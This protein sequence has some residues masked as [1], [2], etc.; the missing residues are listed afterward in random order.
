MNAMEL[1][2][3]QL[4]K[5]TARIGREVEE[6]LRDHTVEPHYSAERTAALLEIT[7]RTV[8]N[9]VDLGERT[10]GKEGIYP[11]VKIS[12]KVVRIPASSINRWLKS[13]TITVA[14]R[15]LHEAIV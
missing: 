14:T 7:L 3:E 5:V 9:Y 12:H 2:T 6:W 4:G 11:V 13:K 1:T 15:E 8:W 10:R